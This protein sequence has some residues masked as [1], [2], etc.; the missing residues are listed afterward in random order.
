MRK[1]KTKIML[2]IVQSAIWFAKVYQNCRSTKS[3]VSMGDDIT[4]QIRNVTKASHRNLLCYIMLK[5]STRIILS[6]VAS[7]RKSTYSKKL[8]MHI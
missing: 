1:P 5:G 8:W 7:A 3:V 4:V 6:Y 2:S